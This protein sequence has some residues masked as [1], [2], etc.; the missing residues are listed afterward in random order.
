MSGAGAITAGKIANAHYPDIWSGLIRG[1]LGE[2]FK[3][4]INHLSKLVQASVTQ[5]AVTV[6]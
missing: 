5:L 2:M 1:L 6:K 4:I 3:I